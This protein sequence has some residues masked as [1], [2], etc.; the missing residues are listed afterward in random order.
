MIEGLPL[1][2]SS[3]RALDV[4][5]DG[6][7]VLGATNEGIFLWDENIGARIIEP[8]PPAPA[9]I[10]LAGLSE[11]GSTFVGTRGEDQS[12]VERE[13]VIWNEGDGLRGLSQLP[14][15]PAN[16]TI[17]GV[18]ADGSRILILTDD[19][20]GGGE[21]AIWDAVNGVRGLGDLE[22]GAFSSTALSISIDG[23]TVV[24]LGSIEPSAS[25]GDTGRRAMIW[26]EADGIRAL[27]SLFGGLYDSV[28]Q[29]VSADGSVVVG[30]DNWPATATGRIGLPPSKAFVW[31]E[32]NGMR[33]LDVLLGSLGIDLTGWE[34]FEASAVSADGLTVLGRASDP[35]GRIQTF[36]AVIPE[37]G[38][39]LLFG[40]GIALLAIRAERR[41]PLQR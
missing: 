37:P 13:G 30:T 26:N 11:D 16:T 5:A 35:N 17:T 10:R 6:S 8:H 15:G 36:I 29:S 41:P 18:S 19:G 21:A 33:A 22:G 38:T 23:S 24:G 27:G 12:F 25:S 39:G 4:S 40:F 31:D 34:I 2:S 28:A 14:G 3:S 9:V 20:F 7:R 1:G 32:V